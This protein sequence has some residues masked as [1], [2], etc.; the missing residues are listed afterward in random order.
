ML[1]PYITYVPTAVTRLCALSFTIVTGLLGCA[2][3][4]DFN[5]SHESIST[6]PF[7]QR[8]ELTARISVRV[9]EKLDSAKIVWIRSPPNETLK[10]FTPFGSQ[11]AEVVADRDG[12]RIQRAGDTT[13]TASA[14]TV[15]DLMA[16]AIGVRLD[17]AALARWVQGFDLQTT[18]DMDVFP[19]GGVVRAWSVQAENLRVIDSARVASRITAISGDTVVR[20]VIDEFR[21]Q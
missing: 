19:G 13:T 8:F 6:M 9:A 5:H 16:V 14:A 7:I 11:I 21:A 10:L 3:A 1:K 18:F 20:V 12:A 15:A 17:T 4:P 2:I